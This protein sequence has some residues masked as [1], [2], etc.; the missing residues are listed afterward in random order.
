VVEEVKKLTDAKVLSQEHADEA[1]KALH[2][3][4]DKRELPFTVPE[5]RTTHWSSRFS[6]WRLLGWSS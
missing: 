3:D 2:P 6:V 5:K 4:P 1:L